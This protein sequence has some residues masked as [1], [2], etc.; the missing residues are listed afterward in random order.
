MNHKSPAP[1]TLPRL[2]LAVSTFATLMTIAAHTQ[3][4]FLPPMQ[5]SDSALNDSINRSNFE[6][7]NDGQHVVFLSTQNF[8]QELFSVSTNQGSVV[9]LSD[10]LV[11]GGDVTVFSAVSRPVTPLRISPNSERVVYVADQRS[12]GLFEL[13]S[14][15]IAGGTVVRLSADLPA[16]GDVGALQRN[17]DFLISSDSQRVVYI[18]DQNQDDTRELFSV[19]LEGGATVQLNSEFTGSFGD[20]VNFQISPDGQRVVYLAD[21]DDDETFELYSVAIAGGTAERLHVDI[22]GVSGD[23]E[24]F[25]ISPDG[26]HVIYMADQDTF[27]VIELYRVAITGG[28]QTRLNA[29]LVSRGDVLGFQISDD[30]SQVVYRADQDIDDTVELY[31]VPILGGATVRLNDDLIVGGGDVGAEFDISADSQ[32]VLYIADQMF[33]NDFDLFS[34]SI[35]GG[36]VTQINPT[37]TNIEVTS[38]TSG[39]PDNAFAISPDSE[40]VVFLT[41]FSGFEGNLRSA[42]INGG[43]AVSLDAINPGS[44][45]ENFQISPDSQRVLFSPS[46]GQENLFSIP[47]TGGEAEQI[48]GELPFGGEVSRAIFSTDGQRIVYISNESGGNR[49][50]LFS[51]G[52]FPAPVAAVLPG[53]R[54][55]LIGDSATAFATVINTNAETLQGCRV[56][57]PAGID[58]EFFY[59]TTDP[60]T[61]GPV[62]NPNSPASIAPGAF[63]TFIFGLTPNSALSPMDVA[64]SFDCSNSVA[65]EVVTGVNTLLLSGS[66]TAVADIVALGATP[67]ADGILTIPGID[68]SAAFA[69][70]SVNVG[71]GATVVASADTGSSNPPLSLFICETNPIDGQCLAPPTSTVETIVA[72]N[73]TPTFS[74]FATA[75]GDVPLD[76]AN[77]RIRV[78]FLEAGVARGTTSVA[79]RTQ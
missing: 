18:A 15:P 22:S 60:T 66:A 32:T 76:P 11:S 5:I 20:V 24:E 50:D 49:F 51:F 46:R 54:S 8:T 16:G 29:D 64:L 14:V 72:A 44:I 57:P 75:N 23:V 1:Q 2:I 73:A 27:G 3:A 52:D 31:S 19:P 28:A 77:T 45:G 12:D 38:F 59:Q 30:S 63:Q 65:A 21:Q 70:A 48:N 42:P 61:N 10:D 9:R 25:Q 74:I 79:V 13:F 39:L 26:Q 71:S 58:A 4:Q 40:Q 41:D 68:G 17:P 35:A 78:R 56:A 47:I 37:N 34:V 55:V 67:T 53:S 36:E 62:G 7:S 6:I 43:I 33:D 69:V